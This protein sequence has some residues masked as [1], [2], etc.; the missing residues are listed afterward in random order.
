MTSLKGFHIFGIIFRL[1]LMSALSAIFFLIIYF[2]SSGYVM[3]ALMAGF[4]YMLSIDIGGLIGQ[5]VHKCKKNKVA[6][7]EHTN[8]GFLW[9]WTWKESVFHIS[10]T[11]VVGG[12]AGGMSYICTNYSSGAAGINNYIGLAIVGLLVLELILADIQKVYL[13]FGLVRNCVYPRSVLKSALFKLRKKK[14]NGFGYLRRVLVSFS[15]FQ[16]LTFII[17]ICRIF[18]ININTLHSSGIKRGLFLY[19]SSFFS[20]PLANAKLSGSVI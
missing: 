15:K 8:T 6:H 16:L 9:H 20:L 18:I 7:S 11:F 13:C 5:I 10:V 19:C 17:S 4:G 3:M 1:L 14:L 12:L 2:L